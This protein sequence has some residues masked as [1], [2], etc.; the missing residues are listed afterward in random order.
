[1]AEVAAV[2]GDLADVAVHVVFRAAREVPVAD[3]LASALRVV[4]QRH[5]RDVVELVERLAALGVVPE[6]HPTRLL[7]RRPRL[8]TRAR[9]DCKR[10]MHSGQESNDQRPLIEDKSACVCA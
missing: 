3:A 5:L 2:L 4:R 1:M 7:H 9:W 8:D 6:A 10:D